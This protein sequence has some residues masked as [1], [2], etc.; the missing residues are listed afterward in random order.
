MSY[1]R[2]LQ[3]RV[4]GPPAPRSYRYTFYVYKGL[5]RTHQ[6]LEPDAKI[7]TRHDI[8]VSRFSITTR[9][10]PPQSHSLHSAAP[11]DRIG[12]LVFR[13]PSQERHLRPQHT[14]LLR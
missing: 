8:L 12:R 7:E 4:S 10:P 3:G 13:G 6:V 14:A 5:C 2:C 9:T 1:R 11:A